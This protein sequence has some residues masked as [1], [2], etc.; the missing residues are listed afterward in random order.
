M[1][2]NDTVYLQTKV[3]T[4]YLGSISVAWTQ[5]TLIK[6]DVQPMNKE[7]AYI[8]YGLTD[9][10]SYKKVYA[11]QGTN[12]QEGYQVKHNN[13]QWL[14]RLVEEW[15]DIGKSNHTMAILSEVI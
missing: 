12:F 4:N 13:K 5:S 14:V 2:L 3:E 11:M 6:C 1:W 9:S 10:N 7:K 8:Q 15:N